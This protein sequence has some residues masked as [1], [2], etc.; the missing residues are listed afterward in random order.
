MDSS[1]CNTSLVV[2]GISV[3]ID[4]SSSNKRFMRLDLPTFGWPTITT[5]IPSRSNAPVLAEINT[6]SSC[7][8]T[9]ANRSLMASMSAAVMSSSEKSIVAS[10]ETRIVIS[11]ALIKPITLEKSPLNERCALITAVSVVAS[12]RS[13]TASA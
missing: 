4:T 11:S 9:P 13:A 8:I 7:C 6:V 2:P 1:F 10:I 12:I 5:L 3:T